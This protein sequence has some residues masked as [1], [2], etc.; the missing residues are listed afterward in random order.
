MFGQAHG[1]VFIYFLKTVAP[2]VLTFVFSAAIYR[3]FSLPILN[4]IR[5]KIK[6]SNAEIVA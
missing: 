1:N 6:K 3:W 4:R 5:D 2:L